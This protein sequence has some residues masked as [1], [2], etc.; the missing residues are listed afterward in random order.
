MLTNSNHEP[1]AFPRSPR[2]HDDEMDLIADCL[3]SIRKT[4]SFRPGLSAETREELEQYLAMA[5]AA[6]RRAHAESKLG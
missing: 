4:S 5:E 1:I 2:V 3:E 6:L